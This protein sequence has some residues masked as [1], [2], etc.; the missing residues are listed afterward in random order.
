MILSFIF[1]HSCVGCKKEDTLLCLSCLSKLIP[2]DKDEDMENLALFFYK[3]TRVRKLVWH[4]KFKGITQVANIF[5]PLFAEKILSLVED[6]LLIQS[7]L[8]ENKIFLIPA[9][10][11]GTSKL[12]RKDHSTVL[13]KAICLELGFLKLQDQLV[14]KIKK[15][16]RQVA[17]KDRE[18]R[19]NNLKNAF[20]ISDSK[21]VNKKI[22]IVI[23][24]VTTTGTT[25]N[26]IRKVL[27]NAGA[28]KVF[29]LTIA[30]R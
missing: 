4:L 19:I 2:A 1:P 25:I 8:E 17:C 13:A 10:S 27:T 30:G 3:D 12:K 15:T 23:D 26:E 5:A 16:K 21:I 28:Q 29:G 9:P 20:T 6:D 7:Y 11:S 22:C 14:K 18:E 24:D